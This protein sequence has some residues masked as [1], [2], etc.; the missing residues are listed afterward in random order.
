M[1]IASFV[2]NRLLNSR[3]RISKRA[4]KLIRIVLIKYFNDPSCTVKIHGRHLKIPLSHTKALYLKRFAFHD[5]LLGRL[6]DY[7]HQ[8]DGYL[9]CID[10]GANIGDTVSACYRHSTDTFLAIEPNPHFNQFLHD[11]FGAC[12]NVTI[13]DV[14]C[15]SSSKKTKYRIEEKRGTA[16]V[17]NDKSGTL[18]Q[19]KSVDDIV[20]ENPDF[21]DVN[22]LKIDTDGHDFAV[23]SGAKE[24]IATKLP[25]ML[26]ECEPFGSETYVE[27]C[28][29]TLT[30]LKNSG[31]DSFLVYSNSGYLIGKHSLNELQYFK[32][33]LIYQLT[34][35]SLYFDILLMKEEEIQK[36]TQLEYSYFIDQMPEK[37]LQQTA[38]TAAEF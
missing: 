29:E 4:W 16:S 20:E 24:I 23:I 11:N 17:I 13:L 8:K 30:L 22:L 37:T 12:S 7:I 28:L 1:K 26:F 36:F 33:L 10:V 2:Y 18:M 6:S 3:N 19:V 27:D 32:Q 21:S 34:S 15:S 38:R 9:K 25:T 31:Y 35:K 14:I 5:R